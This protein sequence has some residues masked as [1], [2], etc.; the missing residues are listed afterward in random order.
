VDADKEEA[1][2]NQA[3]TQKP[4]KDKK[5]REKGNKKDA[6]MMYKPKSKSTTAGPAEDT[7]ENAS[8]QY[9]VKKNG[10]Q[11]IYKKKEQQSPNLE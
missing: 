6:E 11:R 2:P 4:K 5:K 8:V 10:E 3:D 9:K 1:Q 7:G